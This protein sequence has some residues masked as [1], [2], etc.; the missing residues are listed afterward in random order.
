MTL[1]HRTPL[2]KPSGLHRPEMMQAIYMKS[3]STL[4]DIFDLVKTAAVEAIRSGNEAITEQQLT[5]LD[6]VPPS[7]R[8]TYTRRL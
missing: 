6:W 8:R 2:R 3:E 1:E 7:K 4:G 5:K